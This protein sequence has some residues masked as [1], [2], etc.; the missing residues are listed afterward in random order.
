MSSRK[1]SYDGE[2]IDDGYSHTEAA[3]YGRLRWWW[4]GTDRAD[5][6]YPSIEQLAED[7]KRTPKQV[8]R[9]IKVLE[10]SWLIEVT[11]RWYKRRNNY[12]I[13]DRRKYA[14]EVGYNGD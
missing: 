2:M 7:V 4:R 6:L 11:R 10:E 13:C 8:Q 14:P 1:I 5:V 9:S 3:V 12:Y